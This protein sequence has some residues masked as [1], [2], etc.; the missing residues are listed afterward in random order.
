MVL[1]G[2]HIL[3][4]L[5]SVS[6]LAVQQGALGWFMTRLSHRLLDLAFQPVT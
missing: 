3:L 1:D 5:K 4:V 2:T 6:T